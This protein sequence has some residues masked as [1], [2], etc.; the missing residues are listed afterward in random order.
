MSGRGVL[1]PEVA[2]KALEVGFIGFSLKELRLLPY[3]H[4]LTINTQVLN[5]QKISGEERE[6][7]NRWKSEGWVV[8]GASEPVRMSR[9]FWDMTNEILW[10][11]YATCDY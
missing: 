8:G 11:A 2:A 10:L 5:P 9:E 7:F 4:Y 3:V 1:S 6:V